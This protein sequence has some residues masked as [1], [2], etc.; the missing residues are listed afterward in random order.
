LFDTNDANHVPTEGAQASSGAGSGER[1]PGSPWSSHAR[2]TLLPI[3]LT[4][5]HVADSHGDRHQLL[6]ACRRMPPTASRPPVALATFHHSQKLGWC[7]F[8]SAAPL[9]S[10]SRVGGRTALV[11]SS[12]TCSLNPMDS[13]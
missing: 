12:N 6:A 9:S 2:L 13:Q 8:A 3:G 10:S 1:P 11:M 5:R 4:D 7:V